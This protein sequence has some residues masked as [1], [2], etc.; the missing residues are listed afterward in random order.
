MA[1]GVRRIRAAVADDP[2]RFTEKSIVKAVVSPGNDAAAAAAGWDAVARTTVGASCQLPAGV[3]TEAPPPLQLE[4][5][6]VA[7]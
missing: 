3:R 6:L 2:E 5:A 4:P 7:A 1:V